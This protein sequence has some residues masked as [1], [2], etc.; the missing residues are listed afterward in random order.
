MFHFELDVHLGTEI[1]NSKFDRLSLLLCGRMSVSFGWSAFGNINTTRDNFICE[2]F[3]REEE[4][5]FQQHLHM[6][7]YKA[8][9]KGVG[10]GGRWG[11]GGDEVGERWGGVGVS[12]AGVRW[13]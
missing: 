7:Q 10:D 2:V 4:V 12:E 6:L 5:H 9:C 8:N 3:Q 13:G 1:C 11:R